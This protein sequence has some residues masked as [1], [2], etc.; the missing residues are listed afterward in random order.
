MTNP[1]NLK[2]GP[3]DG[4]P[5]LQGSER[6]V[7]WAADIRDAALRRA[8]LTMLH[9][10]RDLVAKACEA[11]QVLVDSTSAHWWIEHRADDFSAPALARGAK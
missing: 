6:Q 8:L 5:P 11:V 1:T 2:G 7:A 9:V 10:P 4:L 3:V